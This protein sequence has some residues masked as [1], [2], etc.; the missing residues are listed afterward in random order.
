MNRKLLIGIVGVLCVAGATGG[1][2]L[3]G[4]AKDRVLQY[5]PADTVLFAGSLKPVEIRKYLDLYQW[6]AGWF[7][8]AQPEFQKFEEAAKAKGPL[9]HFLVALY[10]DYFEQLRKGPDHVMAYYGLADK[11]ESAI[12]LVGALPVMRTNLRDSG[13]FLKA[14]MAAEQKSGMTPK[15]EK[16]GS[17]EL[18]RYPIEAAADGKP[19]LDLIIAVGGN[20]VVVT[21]DTSKLDA[22]TR[23]IALGTQK[24]ANSLAQGKLAQIA[25]AH[26][27]DDDSVFYLDFVE[28]SKALVDPKSSLLGRQL[29]LISGDKNPFAEIQ[30]PA[31]QK[32]IPAFVANVP[33]LV[34]GLKSYKTT[35][36]GAEMTAVYNLEIANAAVLKSLSDMQGVLPKHLLAKA[37][38]PLLWIG[39]GID[40]D[41]VASTVANM[42]RDFGAQTYQC[43][44]L[45]KAQ[46]SVTEKD[47]SGL[48]MLGMARGAKGISA[49]FYSLDL[50]KAKGG[51][52]DGI[53]GIVTFSAPDPLVLW[54][55]AA[56]F[57]PPVTVPKNG[58]PVDVPLPTGATIKVALK[59]NHLVAYL[60]P[61]GTAAA[62][63]LAGQDLTPNGMWT[64]GYD[65]GL[66]S[67]LAL[68]RPTAVAPTP[69]QAEMEKLF[70]NMAGFKIGAVSDFNATGWRNEL[71]IHIPKAKPK[72]SV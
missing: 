8:Q 55:M 10:F 66:L 35:D 56:K 47:L 27:L 11:T 53:D 72:P 39:W 45:L 33:R 15:I 19:G 26:G 21:A 20:T 22:Q 5:V 44:P 14:V 29:Q 64:F 31:C 16:A 51:S 50:A 40:V 2:L 13:A 69:E 61:K 63:Q 32:E 37:N 25:K 52:T 49:A 54:Q 67:Q 65:Y 57:L 71:T 24:P 43:E 70:Q 17:L 23:A 18:R 7:D 12:Y 34:G 58:D 48:V 62:Q 38:Q 9:A 42:V 3:F 1:Y 6:S 36:T 30:T 60:G 46:K 4:G 28:I 68:M 41:K 59:G